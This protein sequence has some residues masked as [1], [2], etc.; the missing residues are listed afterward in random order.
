MH[1]KTGPL[2]S[3]P[4]SPFTSFL[5]GDATRTQAQIAAFCREHGLRDLLKHF[6][7]TGERHTGEKTVSFPTLYTEKDHFTKTGPGQT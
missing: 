7:H 6:D 4:S 2:F 3:Q 5:G 1:S